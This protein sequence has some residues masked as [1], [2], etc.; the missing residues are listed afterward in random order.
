MRPCPSA[1]DSRTA[2]TATTTV[3]PAVR[4]VMSMTEEQANAV[5]QRDG[6]DWPADWH[7]DKEL[8]EPHAAEVWIEEGGLDEFR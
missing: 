4:V 8:C 6:C 3:G 2:S 1:I 5:C 7:K